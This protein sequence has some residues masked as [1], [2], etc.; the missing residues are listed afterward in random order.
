MYC[1]EKREYVIWDT[2]KAGGRVPQVEE[3]RWM[4]DVCSCFVRN[5]KTSGERAAAASERSLLHGR[6]LRARAHQGLNSIMHSKLT[7][8]FRDFN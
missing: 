1:I 2:A 7:I 3:Q 6:S 4:W 5:E 8:P